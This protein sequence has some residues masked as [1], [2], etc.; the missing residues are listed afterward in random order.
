MPP[1]QSSRFPWRIWPPYDPGP[2]I[3][4]IIQELDNERQRAVAHALLE[5]QI[6]TLTAQ[7]ST[8]KAVQKAIGQG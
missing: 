5:G 7:I 8:L 1:E 4:D 3:W 2:P 6:A